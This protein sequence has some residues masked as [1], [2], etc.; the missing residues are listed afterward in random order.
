MATKRSTRIRNGVPKAEEAHEKTA[1][2]TAASK[3]QSGSTGSQSEKVSGSLR[4]SNRTKTVTSGDATGEEETETPT[5]RSSNGKESSSK[6]S[7]VSK[8]SSS[9]AGSTVAATDGKSQRNDLMP[10][11]I[12]AIFSEY[13]SFN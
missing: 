9:K 4:R 13:I 7:S 8:E 6:S 2:V 10:D 12:M 1:V 3:N 5:S 11:E